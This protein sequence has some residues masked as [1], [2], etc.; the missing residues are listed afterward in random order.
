[1]AFPELIRFALSR[2]FVYFG[3]V[4][5]YWPN[6]DSYGTLNLSSEVSTTVFTYI[7]NIKEEE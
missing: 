6:D 1:M 7:V 2:C 3:F 4:S 5:F